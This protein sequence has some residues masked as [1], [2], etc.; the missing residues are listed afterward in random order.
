MGWKCQPIQG[1]HPISCILSQ[2]AWFD[3]GPICAL[4]SVLDNQPCFKDVSDLSN[5][6][7]QDG[8]S[9]RDAVAS[10]CKKYIKHLDSVGGSSAHIEDESD[11]KKALDE[12]MRQ[13]AFLE[14]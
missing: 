6:M 11:T 7:M 10:M 13:K 2:L 8:K 12:I 3:N 4:G 14:R 5:L 1:R 9:L